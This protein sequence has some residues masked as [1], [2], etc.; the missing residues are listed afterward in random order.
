MED[1]IIALLAA[2]FSGVRNDGLRQ[3]VRI[4][5]LQCATEDE[6][7]DNVVIVDVFQSIFPF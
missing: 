2:Q 7:K 5:A 3:L 4:L 6:A 1:R